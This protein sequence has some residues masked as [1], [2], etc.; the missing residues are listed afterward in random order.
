MERGTE[1]HHEKSQNSQM[2]D[3]DF[4][5][6]FTAYDV[7]MV[8]SAATTTTT[9]WQTDRQTEKWNLSPSFGGVDRQTQISSSCDVPF[10]SRF[11][12]HGVW[13][14]VSTVYNFV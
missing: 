7:G 14:Y 9:V 12:N 10:V 2:P 8:T 4:N 6:E 1:E 11:A 3:Q 5:L 13:F